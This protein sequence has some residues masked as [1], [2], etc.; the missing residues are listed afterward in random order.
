MNT[1]VDE[2]AA[3]HHL[4]LY[5]HRYPL[6]V[7]EWIAA[8]MV[9]TGLSRA[10]IIE[11]ILWDYVQRVEAERA[12]AVSSVRAEETVA[13]LIEDAKADVRPPAHEPPRK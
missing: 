8:E 11:R 13:R 9:K 2:T 3:I 6:A 12:K 10:R 7:E 4:V 5:G 1:P